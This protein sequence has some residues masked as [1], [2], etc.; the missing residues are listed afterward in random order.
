VN[1][2][3]KRLQ[4]QQG[5]TLIEWSICMAIMGILL[6]AALMRL[7]TAMESARLKNTASIM[8]SDLRLMQAKALAEGQYYEIR[9]DF[10]LNQY[11]ILRGGKI[12]KRVEFEPGISYY[13]TRTSGGSYSPSLFYYATGAPSSGATIAIKDSHGHKKYIIVTPAI[14]RVRVSQQPPL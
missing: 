4:D 5:F 2:F 8:K 12:L 10:D 13:F 7:D 9:F 1:A 3:C 14:G 6:G 11:R